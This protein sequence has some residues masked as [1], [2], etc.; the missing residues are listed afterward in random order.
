MSFLKFL[1]LETSQPAGTP[2]TETVRKIADA[3]DR[4]DPHEARYIAAFAYVLARAAQA[5]MQISEMETRAMERIVT[6]H[7]G[8]PEEQ[9]VMVVQIAK[10]QN[11]LFGATEDF[12]VTREFNEIATREQKLALLNCLFSVAASEGMISM[13]EDNVIRQIAS[14][15]RLDH[16]DFIALRSRYRDH[17]SVLHPRSE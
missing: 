12:V 2:E 5:D 14:E 15:L 1:G 8:L 13:E 17:L 3:L 6:Q 16:P 10:T 11:K 4:M 7:S 9:A